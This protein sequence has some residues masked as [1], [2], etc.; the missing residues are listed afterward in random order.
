MSAD[1]DIKQ[2]AIVRGEDAPAR[3]RRRHIVS[4]YLV[5]GALVAGFALLVLWA[6]RDYLA[7]PTD[8]WVVPV[9]ASQS[10]V[11]SEGTPLFQAAGWVESRPTP[12]RVAALA[13]STVEKLLV[14]EDQEVKA[15]QPVA[16]LVKQDAQLS[17]DAAVANLELRKAETE[18]ISAGLEAATT[19]LNYPV[20][21]EAT[22]AEAEAALA[23]VAAERKNLPFETRRAEAESK[24]ASD[25]YDRKLK[26]GVA[27]AGRDLVKAKSA[28][29]AAQAM[30][31]ELQNRAGPLAQQEEALTQRRDALKKQLELLTDE[32]QAKQQH[33]AK[34]RAALANE[35]QAAVAVAEAKL[36]LERM[37][38][39]A[40]VDGRVYQ[41]VAFPGTTLTGG[42]GL[43]PNADGSTVVTMYQPN[44]MQVRVDARF[45]DIPKVSLGQAVQIKNPALEAPISGKVLFVSS[46]ANIQKNTL[47]VKVAIDSPASVLKP[48]MLVDVTFLAPKAKEEKA[49]ATEDFRL[50]LPQPVVQQGEGGAYVWL[51]DVSDKVAHRLPVTIGNVGQGGLVEVSGEGL[52]VASRVIARGFE[53]LSDG[54]RIRIASEEVAPV[55][56]AKSGGD[57]A[58]MSRLPHQEP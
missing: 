34:H 41:L 24:F 38:V 15:G 21:L 17:Y 30:V 9:L 13:P 12:I 22:L 55:A 42:M 14:V 53:G 1:V 48:E 7:P 20:H 10:S 40:P 49:T 39:R 11:Q 58:A 43:V 27:V 36:R 23:Q 8:V 57:H 26:A 37:T 33:E 50:Y 54:A 56:A 44:M 19:R 29:D 2:L 32:K 51:A 3:V 28:A 31:E 6:S 46:V 47:Q 16:E 18:E 35:Q 52:T 45:E 5:P 4:R 25:D